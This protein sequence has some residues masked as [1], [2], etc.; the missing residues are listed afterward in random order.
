MERK[1]VVEI[2]EMKRGGANVF[3]RRA[4]P[5]M[6]KLVDAKEGCTWRKCMEAEITG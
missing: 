3:S 5:Q 4:M 2:M 1:R 6:V